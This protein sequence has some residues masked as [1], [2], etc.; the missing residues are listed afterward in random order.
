MTPVQGQANLELTS[1]K[2]GIFPEYDHPGVLV[3]LNI[4]LAE[5][6][7]SSRT[8][9]F[10]VPARSEI[11]S[12]ARL[13]A[14]GEKS[15][16]SHELSEFGQWKDIL[17]ATAAQT[18]QIEYRDPGLVSEEDRRFYKYQWLAIYPVETLSI[19][20]RQPFG[21]GGIQA[22]PSLG[23]GEKGPGD[24]T[25]YS[26]KVGP[27]P[28]GELFT[29]KL[30]YTKDTAN[31]TYPAFDVEPVEPINN[32]TPGR[33]PSPMS[34]IL[35]LLTVATAVLLLVSL[36][37]WWFKANIMEKQESMVQG[38]GILNPEKQAVYCHECGM[39]SRPVDSYCSN[40]GTEL[41]RPPRN[42]RQGTS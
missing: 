8:L 40:C 3:V 23:W 28:A 20:V 7:S 15:P 36:Y 1:V 5:G 30:M 9:T 42:I 35:W 29:L 4:T 21:A 18:I 17:F 10:Q 32:T 16:L 34:V 11:I 25:Y 31:L 2:V 27:I 13:N 6:A 39:R 22:E 37:Y 41:R 33:T 14:D 12:V 24:A 19:T 38:V 26:Q